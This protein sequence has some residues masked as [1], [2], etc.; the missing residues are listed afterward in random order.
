MTLTYSAAMPEW[1]APRKDMPAG[2]WEVEQGRP[3]RGDAWADLYERRMRVPYGADPFSRVVRAHELMHA[4][5]TPKYGPTDLARLDCS[6][7]AA[8]SAEEFR[9][10]TLVGRAG[11]NLDDLRD[12]SE[13][14]SGE[15]LAINEDWNGLVL[16]TAAVAGTK[17][18]KDVI[19]GVRRHN[20]DWAA[21]LS[22]LNAAMVK[23]FKSVQTWALADTKPCFPPDENNEDA[24]FMPKGCVTYTTKVAKMIDHAIKVGEP[25]AESDE[26]A[27]Q[28]DVTPD[29]MDK[30]LKV[31]RGNGGL[32]IDMVLDT[33]IPLTRTLKGTMGRRR[34]A[35]DTGRNPRRIERALTDPHRRIFDKTTKGSGGVVLIDQS[36]SMHLSDEQVWALVTAAPGCLIVG[37]SANAYRYDVPNVW[38][39][40]DR[41]RVCESVREG[42]G[43]NGCD[44]PALR[45]ALSRRKPG[46]QVVWVCDG[47]VTGQ[48][49][50]WHENLADEVVELVAAH[51]VHMVDNLD[52]ALAALQRIKAGH[53]LPT[54]V[55]GSLKGLA[56]WRSRNVEAA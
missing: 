32:W 44:G 51:R 43:G 17:A 25:V 22:K 55:T 34:I 39:L 9:V 49:D 37:Y 18:V 7:Q 12:G 26:D 45:Y 30:A 15:S 16:F 14:N 33:S 31:A 53:R 10:N 52:G 48:K 11:F 40:A 21:A 19:T 2:S 47:V 23:E 13:T 27:A 36:G 50:D 1:L 8:V 56:S 6:A 29:R 3:M 54:T 35:T 38:V 42:N 4:Q 41:G 46:E 20:K 28:P 5:I 24:E